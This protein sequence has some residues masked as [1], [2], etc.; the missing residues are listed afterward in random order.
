[1]QTTPVP[2]TL[3]AVFRAALRVFGPERILFG[4][5]STS[6]P[7][8]WRSDVFEARAATLAPLISPDA[9][10]AIFGGN[11]ARLLPLEVR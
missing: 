1:M 9:A 5:D 11:L 8:G 7:R 3:A 4:T 6:F 10:R 2:I